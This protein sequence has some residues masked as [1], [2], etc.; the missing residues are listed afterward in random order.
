MVE[1][2]LLIYFLI[3]LKYMV[4]M[5]HKNVILPVL[6]VEAVVQLACSPYQ[7]CGG[8]IGIRTGFLASRWVSPVMYN[9]PIVPC[10]CTF[11]YH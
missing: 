2:I 10:Y 9:F 8:K 6:Y 5:C 11:I 3:V 1:C 4:N 7:I